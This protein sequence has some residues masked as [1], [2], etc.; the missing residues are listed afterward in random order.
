MP[1]YAAVY[2]PEFP[3]QAL[4]RLRGE[5]RGKAVA[6]IEGERP[7]E[8][9]C[10]MDAKARKVGVQSGM[11]R[12]E[13]EPFTIPL[14]RRSPK[15]E[16][17]AKSVL[18]S[19]LAA[20][21]S[22]IEEQGGNTAWAYVLDLS[23]TERLLGSIQRSAEAIRSRASEIGFNVRI[24]VADD[25]HTALCLSRWA[26]TRIVY[27]PEGD[28]RK[29]LSPL[30][31][32]SIEMS[33]E[34][35][36][37]FSRWGLRTLGDLADLPEIDL[38]ARLGQEGKRLRQLSRG[39]HPHLFL[40]IQA[41][42]ALEEYVEFDAP[43]ESLESL[44]FAINPMLEQ[45]L[46]RAASRALA[47]SSLALVFE[48]ENAPAHACGVRPAL[49][50]EDR[51]MLLKLLQLDLETHGPSAGVLS[52]RLTADPGPV[53][54]VQIGLF[55]PQLP[56]P[57]RLEVTLARVAAIVGEGR[58]GRPVLKDTHQGGGFTMQRFT[59]EA[60][61]HTSPQLSRVSLARRRFRPPA[62]LKVELLNG[63]LKTLWHERVR[64]EVNRIYGPWRTSGDWWSVQVWS[65]EAW[66]F[67]A[68]AEDGSLLLGIA[69]CD[70]LRQVWQLEALY[71]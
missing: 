3:T 38:I 30:P 55:S 63:C 51:R 65:S 6:V 33:E 23:G 64:Y 39:E 41:P 46:K 17:S 22:R 31:L 5:L 47:I 15:E 26:R 54:K 25:F 14:L 21:T 62:A 36:E 60:A 16:A 7:F 34:D 8:R 13:V 68:L 19:C 42:F 2:V 1:V 66:D 67:A 50:T 32:T 45:L 10:S 27:V 4:L 48:L 24:A 9:I 56:E 44:L 71:D 29:S 18:L 43:V 59:A 49:P 70:R 69:L 52:V 20:F 35:A 40:P 53:S 28:R 11:T 61:T 12:A 37:T 58:V 57:T